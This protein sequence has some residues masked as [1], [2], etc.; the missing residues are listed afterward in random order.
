[1]DEPTSGLD[2]LMQHE[3]FRILTELNAEG[4]TVFLSS[5]ILSEVQAH[6]RTAAFI[7]DGHI[8]ISDRV[9]KLEN[10]GAKKIVLRGTLSDGFIGRLKEKRSDVTD[11]II[12][13]KYVSYLYS[14]DIAELLSVLAAEKPKDVSITEPTMEEIFMNYYE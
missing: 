3:F 13:D 12:E 11:L 10:T 14:G 5:H 4:S 8:I 2:P 7:K 6:C 9:D 1:M